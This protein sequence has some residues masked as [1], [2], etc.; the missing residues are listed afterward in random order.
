MMLLRIHAVIKEFIY[1]NKWT[2]L[3][4]Q[5]TWQEKVDIYG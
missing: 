1:S 2:Q 3:A 5:K 4:F